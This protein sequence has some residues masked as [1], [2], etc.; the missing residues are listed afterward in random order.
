MYMYTTLVHS[1]LT[2]ELQGRDGAVR[3]QIDKP[4]SLRI[5]AR[6]SMLIWEDETPATSLVPL[7]QQ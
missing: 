7:R 1:T 4:G 6:P 3:Q 2:H 5:V